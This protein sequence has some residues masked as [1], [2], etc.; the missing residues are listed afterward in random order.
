MKWKVKKDSVMSSVFVLV[1]QGFVD[2]AEFFPSYSD[3]GDRSIAIFCVRGHCPIHSEPGLT[4]WF[5]MM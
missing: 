5:V 1:E 3:L 4:E 2:P